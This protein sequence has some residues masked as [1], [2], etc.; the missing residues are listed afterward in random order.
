MTVMSR[1]IAANRTPNLRLCSM[2]EDG[3]HELC[4][5]R[6]VR[7]ELRPFDCKC[8]CLNAR[9]GDRQP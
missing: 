7:R 6:L 3:R 8:L 5:T 4:L 9:T 2:C 1:G